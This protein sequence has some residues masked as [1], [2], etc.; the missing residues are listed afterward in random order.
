LIEYAGIRISILALF[1]LF[2]VC[3]SLVEVPGK[4][5]QN[6]GCIV[7]D[8]T[9]ATVLHHTFRNGIRVIPGFVEGPETTAQQ[10][11]VIMDSVAEFD[12]AGIPRYVPG[13]GR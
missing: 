6:H 10:G 13:I 12:L 11:E 1:I 3:F 2:A 9:D 8:L 4:S 5:H 7:V